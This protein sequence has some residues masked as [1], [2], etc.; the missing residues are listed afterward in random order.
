MRVSTRDMELRKSGSVLPVL[1]LLLLL[2]LQPVV[3]GSFLTRRAA[4][5]FIEAMI[6]A[7]RDNSRI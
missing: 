2:L 1:L 6:A 3:V 7:A 5:L 4:A